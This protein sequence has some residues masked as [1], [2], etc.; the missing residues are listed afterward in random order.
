MNSIQ[1]ERFRGCDLREMDYLDPLADY[2][3]RFALFILDCLNWLTLGIG[4]RRYET[5]W[6]DIDWTH[7]RGWNTAEL[8]SHHISKLN[9]NDS[10]VTNNNLLYLRGMIAAPIDTSIEEDEVKDTI[11]TQFFTDMPPNCLEEIL[12]KL[13][14]IYAFQREDAIEKIRNNPRST[15]VLRAVESII[16]SRES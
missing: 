6:E 11:C 1:T 16:T 5:R 4:C 3:H 13:K 12:T 2:V 14:E 8:M 7:E 9:W 15:E 10:D